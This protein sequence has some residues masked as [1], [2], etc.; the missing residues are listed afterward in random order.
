M[1]GTGSMAFMSSAPAPMNAPMGAGMG[2]NPTT[3][4]NGLMMGNGGGM[5]GPG[6]PGSGGLG[7]THGHAHAHGAGSGSGSMGMGMGMG[8]GVGVGLPGT[9]RKGTERDAGL[10]DLLHHQWIQY[11]SLFVWL[12]VPVAPAGL[13]LTLLNGASRSLRLARSQ[14]CALVIWAYG[15]ALSPSRSSGGAALPARPST[16]GSGTATP[17][18]HILPHPSPSF[19]MHGI[20]LG[21]A[22]ARQSGLQN[23]AMTYLDRMSTRSPEELADVDVKGNTRAVL[24]MVEKE[25]KGSRWE[26]GR[27]GA[28][29][30]RKLIATQFD[31]SVGA[32]GAGR[33]GG[34]AGAGAA[35]AG[36]STA[37]LSTAGSASEP[38]RDSSVVVPPRAS[39]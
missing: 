33:A 2:M 39:S 30:L 4:S 21:P 7:L 22:S 27:E 19:N 26:L 32:G 31:H 1:L 9:P 6:S 14:L 12:V 35:T 11:V 34:G 36:R 20:P 18:S 3:Q 25:L 23:E 5:M 38:S 28:G 17:N 8:L 15:Q 16:S 24:E 10:D 37:R 29:V 13:L